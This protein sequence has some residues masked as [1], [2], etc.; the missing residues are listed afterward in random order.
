MFSTG[1]AAP[2]STN[3]APL[4]T[5]WQDPQ[6]SA[7][8]AAALA[9]T[10]K[11]DGLPSGQLSS[12]WSVAS[13]P[14][15]ATVVFDDASAASTI[16][17]FSAKGKYVLRL[18]ATDGEQT[19]QTDVTVQGDVATQGSNVAPGATPTASFTAGWN[20]VGAVNDGKVLYNGGATT[21]V[22]GTWAGGDNPATRWLQYDWKE[23][24]RVS[25]LEMNF[26][27]DQ[28]DP[29]SNQGVNVPS[30]WKV[31]YW[32][33]AA[34]ADVPSASEYTVNRDSPNT[35]T[36]GAVTTTRLRATLSAAGSGSTFA[37]VAVSEWKVFADAPVSIEPIDIRTAV[38]T[39]PDLP[40]TVDATFSDGGHADLPVTWAEVTEA[41]VAGEGSFPVSGVVP[42][43]PVAAKATVWV[44]ATAPGQINQVDAVTTRT[45]PGVAPV[46]PK[47]VGVL[48]NDGSRQDLPVTWNTV[49]AASYATPGQFTVEGTVQSDLP[50]TKAASAVVTVGG[51]GDDAEAPTVTFQ[52]SPAA[53]T[54]A[55]TPSPSRSTSPP[56]MTRTRLPA[57]RCASIRVP[58]RPTPQQSRWPVTAPTWCRRGRRMPPAT[59]RRQP[60]KRCALTPRPPPSRSRPTRSHVR[61]RPRPRMRSRVWPR[62]STD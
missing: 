17:R 39:K 5:A 43:S 40:A 19:S 45:L 59:P 56:P 1:I 57:S 51:G 9:G 13:A 62:S 55:G 58:G 12:T 31:Q 46:L 11:D 44:R 10:V 41:Q 49:D 4:V 27:S 54:P 33:G 50:G 47:A 21:D 38:G 20:N 28:S 36:F 7:A 18:T 24:Q 60:N 15:G 48:F 25:G 61:S 30:A 37:G 53:R 14:D 34:W 26:W 32:D 6:A 23:P 22:W 29:A 3:Q 35:V 8:G 42:G 2:A 52:V 16:A